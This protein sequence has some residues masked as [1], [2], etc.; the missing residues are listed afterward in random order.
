MGILEPAERAAAEYIKAIARFAGSID[1]PAF[2]PGA[3]A[4]GFMLTCAP[5][6]FWAKLS[7]VNNDPRKTNRRENPRSRR[8]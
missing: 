3:C 4:P 6:T 1:M 8:G 7:A 5:R 2:D